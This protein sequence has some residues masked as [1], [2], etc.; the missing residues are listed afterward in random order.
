MEQRLFDLGYL[1]AVVDDKDPRHSSVSG[2]GAAE[3]AARLAEAGLIAICATGTSP[4]DREVQPED[5][6]TVVFLDTAADICETRS[7]GSSAA[8]YTEPAQHGIRLEGG[9]LSSSVERLVEML[10]SRAV[11]H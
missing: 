1:P 10:E 2:A 5:A 4:A 6:S 9:E 3:A 8:P 11:I 7:P